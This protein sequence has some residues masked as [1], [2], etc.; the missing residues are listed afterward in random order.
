M[1]TPDIIPIFSDEKDYKD[2]YTN[3]LDGKYTKDFMNHNDELISKYQVLV[4]CA[5][6]YIID[7]YK[8]ITDW[9]RLIICIRDNKPDGANTEQPNHGKMYFYTEQEWENEIMKKISEGDDTKPVESIT[10]VIMDWSDGDFSLTINGLEFWWIDDSV[11][12]DI[13]SYIEHELNK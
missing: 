12:L 2:Y 5:K 11:V 8:K 1:E 6:I 13:A 9:K 4:N 10:D 3:V 7:N